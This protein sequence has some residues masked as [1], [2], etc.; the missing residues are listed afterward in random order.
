MKKKTVITALCCFV[1]A[2]T[3]SAQMP[4]NV[5]ITGYDTNTNYMGLMLDAAND[6]SP[7]AMAMGSIYEA[8][9]NL[10][11]S[12]NTGNH[13]T[14]FF[15]DSNPENVKNAINTYLTPRCFYS[16][17][18]VYL[19]AKIMTAEAGSDW[20]SDEWKMSVGNVLLNRV[21]SPEF[22]NAVID[23]IYQNGQYY[24]RRSKYFANLVPSQKCIDL[25]YRLCNGERVL[26]A[27]VVFQA[28]YSQGGGCY[29]K[30]H[31]SLLGN[32][33]FCY[34]SHPELY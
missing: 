9:R 15:N 1:F 32:T 22:P 19:V 18:D 13:T 17:E 24:S 11:V 21:E 8:Q 3:A 26:P 12:E 6:G 31:D 33:Y 7:H 23:C 27:D 34:T 2:N 28:N 20:L 16:D 14:N 29:K 30:M 5:A 10:K 4:N 25:A